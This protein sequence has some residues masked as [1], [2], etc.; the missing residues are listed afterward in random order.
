MADALHIQIS[1]YDTYRLPPTPLDQLQ[2]AQNV[3]II[4]I[5]GALRVAAAPHHLAYNVVV[6][7]HNYYPSLYVDCPLR[8]GPY[9]AD[10]VNALAVFLE[11][12]LAESFR[13][14]PQQAS[15]DDEEE[16]DKTPEPSENGP[17]KRFIAS[18]QYCRGTPMYG[19]HLGYRVVLKILFLLSLYKTRFTRLI[20]ERKLDFARFA[21]GSRKKP[22]TRLSVYEAHIN[23]FSQF[24]ADFN[25]FGC[26]WLEVSKC[27]FR[28]PIVHDNGL[29]IDALKK[30]LASHIAHNNILNP[31][32]Y[33]RMGKSMLEIDI[34]VG[35]IC[36]RGRLHERSVHENFSEFTNFQN[37]H[38]I[39]LSSLQLT[40]DELKYQCSARNDDKTSQLLN[41]L[42]SQVFK[43]IGK[44]GYSEWENSKQFQELL[45]YIRKLN[46]ETGI[47][48]PNTYFSK[49]MSPNLADPS[50]PTTF[51]LVDQTSSLR[52]YENV[53]LLNYRDDLV[54]WKYYDQLF[55]ANTAIISGSDSSPGILLGV[56][57]DDPRNINDHEN[58][59][60]FESNTSVKQAKQDSTN[61]SENDERHEK[62][63]FSSQESGS[64]WELDSNRIHG[65]GSPPTLD[66]PE[67]SQGQYGGVDL[68]Y[69]AL[70]QKYAQQSALPLSSDSESLLL[71]Q[72][73]D[74]LLAE[75][76]SIWESVIPHSLQKKRFERTIR[77]AGLLTF[78]YPDPFYSNNADIHAQP[79]IFANRKIIVPYNG[80][81][82]LSDFQIAG[83][84]HIMRSE[85]SGTDSESERSKKRSYTLQFS[86]EAP[87]KEAVKHGIS[88]LERIQIKKRKKFK[89]QIEPAVTQ[90]NDYKYSYRPHHVERN[91]SDF[92]KLT[93]MHMEI[94]VNTSNALL[95]NPRKDAIT[96][97]NFHF[98]NANK[99]YSN[100]T[101]LTTILVNIEKLP[102]KD[103]IIKQLK[104]VSEQIQT[105]IRY[106]NTERELIHELL[107]KIEEYDP[108]ILSGYEVNGSSWGYIIER[109]QERYKENLLP[110]LSRS[111]IF[112]NGKFGDRWGYTHT[113]AIKISGRHMLNIWRLLKSELSL[114]SYT[115]ELICFH[116]LHEK[117]PR[118]RNL[119][120]SKWIQKGTFAQQVMFFKYYVHRLDVTMRIIDIQEFVLRNVEQSRL[121]GV[122][123]YS[124][125]Y[126]GSQF[127]VE[128]ILLRIAKAENLLLNSP[129]KA[130]VHDMRALDVVPLI[131]EPDS[132]FY[133]S[134]LVVLDFQSL[135]PSIM[136]AYNYCYSTLLG[137]I[138]GFNPTS[139]EVGYLK[140]NSLPP[141]IIE[142][143]E[144][145][146][147]LNLSPNGYMFVSARFRKSVLAKMLEEILN[148]RI[149]MKSVAAAFLDD[150]ELSRLLNSK[151]LAMKLIANVTYGYT[152]A[153]FSGRMP[154]SDIADAIVSTGRE[155]MAK[156]IEIIESSEYGAKV[157][158]GDT[159]SLFVYFP[160]KSKDDAFKYGRSLAE[161]V[162]N[163]MPDPIKLKFEKV[164]HP[165]VL[166]AKKRYVG[167]CYE[168]ENQMVP[169]FEAKGIETIRRDGIPAQL[170]MVGKTLR[171]LFETK[172]ISKVKEYVLRQFYKI[173][174]NRV[175]VKDF[176]FAKAVRH[177]TYKNEQYL[178]P[179]AIVARNKMKNDPRSEPQYKERV[180]YLV[181]KDT[182]KER[183]KDRC[184]SPDD[185]IASYSTGNPMELDFEY[186]IK[187]VLIPPLERVFNLM[188]V[189]IKEWYKD[190]LRDTK[191]FVQKRDDIV[192]SANVRLKECFHCKK[193]LDGESLHLCKECLDNEVEVMNNIKLTLKE[194][195]RQ[196]LGYTYIC[197]ECCYG[198]FGISTSTETDTYCCN[199]D[200]E[201]FYAKFKSTNECIHLEQETRTVFEAT[202]SLQW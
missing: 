62:S 30:Y 41:K 28:L 20:A 130:Q 122:D 189:K 21:G 69:L 200:C 158:Y 11:D 174:T 85:F 46:K 70:T 142:L 160:G 163:F 35:D 144:K 47:E 98:D 67:E 64:D 56:G 121:I 103:S 71:T 118:I 17:S 166:L 50:I 87:S 188:G 131:M 48:D 179:G 190:M 115:L 66:Q 135:Y 124:N 25:L 5:Y 105:D 197:K 6:H 150:A 178:P 196:V 73:L 60:E 39:Y 37:S 3:P 1:D 82:S 167:Q 132:N 161:K 100:G 77:E 88:D 8:I 133:K 16:W 194:K 109:F 153:S 154:N 15:D 137:K 177:G 92:L 95:P 13:R 45:P 12:S 199:Q 186:Y 185:Y 113:S 201:I 139:N 123:F 114:T 74:Y 32:R 193:A 51:S 107:R 173:L 140:H 101:G 52:H 156:S 34:T 191:Q 162:T 27:H 68:H 9:T 202:D 146:G 44:G 72:T 63:D 61:V 90:T 110:R 148:M 42:Y 119:N 157:V 198:S 53:P 151:Q 175:N 36:N 4:R 187:K 81:E 79:L 116:V 180:P 93:L 97:I 183:L 18:I 117:L 169:K 49:V 23:F 99:M 33:P 195:E 112:A 138:E 159:D 143:L 126:R 76:K 164:Y 91:P 84:T 108:D 184:Y 141:G 43:N 111:L 26:S 147:G 78:D 170:K 10:Y 14:K 57:I 192:R 128:S 181:I 2:S 104:K 149:N 40:F 172:D 155:L 54:R 168:F 127:K 31:K 24:L 80:T 171:I 94:H 106:C 134:P 59:E 55:E 182:A 120:L 165:C 136:I 65:Q 22:L 152:S 7:V 38:E 58:Y 83:S 89:S 176:C 145:N 96:M 129:S 125:F 29:P 19:Y 75:P 86:L 102:D